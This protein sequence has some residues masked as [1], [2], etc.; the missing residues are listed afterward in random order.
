M[1]RIKPLSWW[2][3]LADLIMTPIMIVLN[4]SSV[5]TPQRTH[6]WNNRTLCLGE[7]KYLSIEGM[8]QVN[9]DPIAGRRWVWILPIFHMRLFGGWSQYVV[10]EPLNEGQ[11]WHCGWH[12]PTV[13][14]GFSR[15]RNRGPVRCLRGD[16]SVR[17][18]GLTAAG[19][20]VPI[21]EIGRGKIGVAGPFSRLP[22][23]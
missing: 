5:D 11:E 15:I 10:L 1:I 3:N 4:W 21:R 16:G 8:V 17:F 20:Q 14:T 23:L 7:S 9:G 19:V 22:L 12:V 13:I 6:R 2:E 18:F